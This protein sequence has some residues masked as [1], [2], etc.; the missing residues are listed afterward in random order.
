MKDKKFYKRDEEKNLLK[1]QI[2]KLINDKNQKKYK[3]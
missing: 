1:V 2:C 3:Q